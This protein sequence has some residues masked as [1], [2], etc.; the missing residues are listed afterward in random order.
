LDFSVGSS[1]G[2]VEMSVVKTLGASNLTEDERETN[3]YYATHPDDLRAFLAALERDKVSLSHRIWEP[4]A[5]ERHL[6]K[7]LEKRGH[8]VFSSDLIIRTEGVT[9]HDFISPLFMSPEVRKQL[10]HP[11]RWNGDILTNPPYAYMS[12][13]VEMGLQRLHSGSK[14][15][16]LLPSRYLEGLARYDE[17]YSKNPPKYI[18]Q[19]SYRIDI[20]KGGEFGGGNAVS[21]C[22]IIWEKGFEG[23]PRFRW[24]VRE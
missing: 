14:M 13:F 3:D 22:W 24:I 8:E 19:Y 11:K 10:D 18:Y 16:L 20:G 5:G 9:Q 17:I 2:E 23:D 7:V 15:L 21:Y 12:E 1:G 6:S 4:A